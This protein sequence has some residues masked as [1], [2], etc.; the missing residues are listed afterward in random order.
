MA[1]RKVSTPGAKT[2]EP[3]VETTAQ[4]TTAEQADAALEHITGQDAESQDQS[5]NETSSLGAL[6]EPTA[7]ELAAKKE[8][9][10]FLQW[11]KTKGE[12]AQPA[13]QHA[14]T[15]NAPTDPTA[16]RTRQVVGPNGWI[17]EEY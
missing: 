7:E 10:E 13:T 17:T 9:E 5:T 4:P 8:Y 15:S 16:K 14:P 12:S 1:A 11:R 6:V 3:T 2:P